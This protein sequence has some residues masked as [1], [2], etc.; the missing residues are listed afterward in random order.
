MASGI[1]TPILRLAELVK[2][3]VG[4]GKEIMCR[5]QVRPGDPTRWVADV[6]AFKSACPNWSPQPMEEAL[7]ETVAAWVKEERA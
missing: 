3:A 6:S 7:R 5:N 2:S 1:E 4:C